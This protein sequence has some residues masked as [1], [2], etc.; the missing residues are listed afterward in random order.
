MGATTELKKYLRGTEFRNEL[1]QRYVRFE[2]LSEAGLRTVVANLLC[3]KIQELGHPARGYTVTC[4]ARLTD[5]IPDVLIWKGGHPR[6]CI[7]LKDTRGFNLRRAESDWQKLQDYCRQYQSVKAGVLIYVARLNIRNFPIK[8]SRQTLRCW[9]IQIS[10]EK[11]T[12]NFKQWEAKFRKRAHY[13]PPE[14]RARSTSAQ[15]KVLEPG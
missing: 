4:E 8:R 9:P 6:I 15:L 5:V 11:D 7:E 1:V 14:R 2:I 12:P 13:T 3:M 10:L